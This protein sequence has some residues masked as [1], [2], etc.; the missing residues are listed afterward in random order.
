MKVDEDKRS[1]SSREYKAS[2]DRWNQP[3]LDIFR[4]KAC[5]PEFAN[6][7]C[8]DHLE[9]RPGSPSGIDFG[10]EGNG[11]SDTSASTCEIDPSSDYELRSCMAMVGWKRSRTLYLCLVRPRLMGKAT[12]EAPKLL[13]VHRTLSNVHVRKWI[14][15]IRSF[16]IVDCHKCPERSRNGDG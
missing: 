16:A 15:L 4:Q 8:L 7:I 1:H 14:L 10:L 11:Q 2:A 3:D 12:I 9:F 13:S 5:I 6:H